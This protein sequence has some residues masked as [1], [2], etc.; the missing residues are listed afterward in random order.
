MADETEEVEINVEEL[1]DLSGYGETNL[2]ALSTSALRS[3][4]LKAKLS[5]E[6]SIAKSSLEHE[7]RDHNNQDACNALKKVIETS[8]DA[9][10]AL[11]KEIIGIR[12][13]K[14]S[15][16]QKCI[17][18]ALKGKKFSRT[19][20][21]MGGRHDPRIHD[22]FRAAVRS[23]SGRKKIDWGKA[24]LETFGGKKK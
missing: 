6:T 17:R 5:W 21:G 7:C 11:E 2:G 8:D 24:F 16:F 3:I 9:D 18:D 22:A 12:T 4:L 20:P 13:R 14:L 19:M 15:E 23:C 10:V 1:F